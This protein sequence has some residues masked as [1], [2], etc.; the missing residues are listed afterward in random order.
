MRVFVEF[1]SFIFCDGLELYHILQILR[2]SGGTVR[3]SCYGA[4]VQTMD[5][6]H[7]RV[8]VLQ[9]GSR[10]WLL[11]STLVWGTPSMYQSFPDHGELRRSVSYIFGALVRSFEGKI[12]VYKSG[13]VVMV[14][15]SHI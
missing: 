2:L 4:F 11:P 5:P 14:G 8:W 10:Y 9:S 6:F 13:T 7:R 3:L 15:Q 1:L 12:S